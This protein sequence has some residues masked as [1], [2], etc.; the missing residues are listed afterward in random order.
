M[1][2]DERGMYL[3]TVGGNDKM[4]LAVWR[5]KDLVDLYKRENN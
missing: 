3:V 5:I 4:S 1:G 2:I